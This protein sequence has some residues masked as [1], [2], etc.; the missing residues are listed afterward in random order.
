MERGRDND[1]DGGGGQP[2]ME[3]RIARLEDDMREVKTGLKEIVSRLVAIEIS[4]AKIDGR[5]TGLEGRLAGIEGRLQ[6]IP[7][8]WQLFVALITTW[9]AGAAIVFAMIRFAPR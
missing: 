8:A 6:A 1:T 3:F 7:S 9:S 2:S 4:L 5:I